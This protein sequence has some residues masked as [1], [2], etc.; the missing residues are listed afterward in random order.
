ML[1]LRPGL[2][3]ASTALLLAIAAPAG[4]APFGELPFRPVPP[5][6]VC[7]RATGVPGELIRWSQ[8][9]FTV[10]QA[11]ADGLHDAGAVKL[12]TIRNCPA[13]AADAAT[14]TAVVAAT[15]TDAFR[16]TVRD[17]AGAWSAPT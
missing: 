10:M 6:A 13:V 5:S 14:G 1:S 17:R 4:A 2:A 12:G 9:G 16:V 11:R 15:T 3:C 7:V 8:G